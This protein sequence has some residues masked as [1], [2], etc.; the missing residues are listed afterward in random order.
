MKNIRLEMKNPIHYVPISPYDIA[1]RTFYGA[2][3]T[4]VHFR[5]I[6]SVQKP[7]YQFAL[8][9]NGKHKIYDTPRY[10]ARYLR[11]K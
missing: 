8:F 4:S 9:E 10:S 7:I 1:V 2:L 5:L 3:Y 6:D 11:K